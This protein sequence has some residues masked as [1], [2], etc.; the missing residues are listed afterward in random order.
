MM[1]GIILFYAIKDSI[2]DIDIRLVL[3]L[4]DI[5]KPFS[6]QEDGNIRHFKG[7]AQKSAGYLKQY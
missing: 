2:N 6:Y 1:F 5:G 4:H 3:L 7:H